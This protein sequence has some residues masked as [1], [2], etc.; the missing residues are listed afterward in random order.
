[1]G[2]RDE[3][4]DAVLDPLRE[5]PDPE[6]HDGQPHRMRL[7]SR[8]AEGLVEGARVDHRARALIGRYEA[9]LVLARVEGDPGRHGPLQ[10]P[11]DLRRGRAVHMKLGP[12]LPQR[13]ATLPRSQGRL[14]PALP[15][16]SPDEA[17]GPSAG[18][19]GESK[20]VRDA[21]GDD[22]SARERVEPTHGGPRHGSDEDRV[23]PQGQDRA[24]VSPTRG[25]LQ[26]EGIVQ[27][28]HPPCLRRRC[29]ERTRV[30]ARNDQIGR[31]GPSIRER[32]V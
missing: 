18:W 9:R 6:R 2:R 26:G 29:R 16:G 8:K 12:C 17:A 13:R 19:A 28:H 15:L 27:P 11:S 31:I 23:R 10:V 14:E 30:V 22:R 3:T 4:V 32:H 25:F 5:G 24:D 21:M 20:D 7:G 1:M